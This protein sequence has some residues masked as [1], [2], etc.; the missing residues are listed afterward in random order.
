MDCREARHLSGGGR[1]GICG[2]QPQELGR[3]VITFQREDGVAENFHTEQNR[4]FLE[5]LASETGGRYWKSSELK[6]LPRDISYSEGGIS[7]R[8]AKELWNM[9]IV[10]L[11]LLGLPSQSGCCGASGV[12]Y[13]ARSPAGRRVLARAP[14]ARG[15]LLRH[16]RRTG[17]RARLRPALHR[18]G[19]G[20]RPHLQIGRPRRFTFS[21]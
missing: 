17:R 11:F 4:P 5:Q 7:V 21:R 9:P 2:R 8:N 20:S 1:S 13:E 6:N 16:R 15:D 14:G 18:S 12:L 3:D 19:K 10:F